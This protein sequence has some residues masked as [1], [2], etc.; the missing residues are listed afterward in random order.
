[1]PNHLADTPTTVNQILRLRRAEQ[2]ADDE[3]RDDLRDVREFLENIVGPTVSRAEAARMLGISQTALDRWVRKGEISAVVTPRGRREIP[4]AELT[5]LLE[6]VDAVRHRGGKRPLAAVMRER[7]RRSSEVIDLDR[8]LPRLR[9]RGHRVAELQSLAYHRLIGERLDEPIVAEA[10]RRLRR[11][12]ESGRIHPEWA[13]EW[14][15]VLRMPLSRIAKAIGADTK[16]AR[17]LRQT[18]PFAGVL[19][20]QERKR[21]TRAV[22]ER[23]LA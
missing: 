6:E 19:T 18:S 20:E 15:R 16:R 4:L 14:E 17:E 7:Q 22:E 9:R 10:R 21:L 12:R 23:A 11:W 1:M 2:F 8:L 13:A 5:G 3:F